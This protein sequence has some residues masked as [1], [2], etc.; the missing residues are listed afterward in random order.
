MVLQ[1][2]QAPAVQTCR[3]HWMIQTADGPVSLGVCQLC[4]E[5]REFMNS[6]DDWNTGKAQRG[7]DTF[8]ADV[9]DPDE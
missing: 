9:F 2:V 6:I 1:E 4:F 5:A 8:D 7:R 3:H